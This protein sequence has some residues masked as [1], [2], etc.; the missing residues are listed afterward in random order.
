MPC[1]YPWKII[2]VVLAA[3][4]LFYLWAA[5]QKPLYQDDSARAKDEK[6]I[7]PLRLRAQQNPLDA[8]AHFELSSRLF[9]SMNACGNLPEAI[10]ECKVA[11]ALDPSNAKY[12]SWM[13]TLRFG[14]KEC[15]NYKAGRK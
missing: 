3:A 11:L 13:H 1:L 6:Y 14:Q 2:T 9:V 10:T 15:E 12:K 8:K 5:P 4:S 7:P